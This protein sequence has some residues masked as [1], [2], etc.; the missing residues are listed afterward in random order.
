MLLY[1]LEIVEGGV[2]VVGTRQV[3]ELGHKVGGVHQAL[4]GC[5]DILGLFAAEVD[6]GVAAVFDDFNTF[7]DVAVVFLQLGELLQCGDEFVALGEGGVGG[8]GVEFVE[9]FFVGVPD[10]AVLLAAL[11]LYAVAV[12]C[13]FLAQVDDGEVALLHGDEV[14]ELTDIFVVFGNVFEGD[15]DL[16]PFEGLQVR[17]VD[18][19]MV[20]PGAQFEG[21]GEVFNALVVRVVAKHA[22]YESGL[23]G[24]EFFQLA[25]AVVVGVVA[26]KV[27][28]V[29][30][31]E[32][33][34]VEVFQLLDFCFV[35]YI[36][37]V[38]D[39]GDFRVF[40]LDGFFEFGKPLVF[41]A[42]YSLSFGA[43]TFLSGNAFGLQSF[44]LQVVVVVGIFVEH[45]GGL[46]HLSGVG[47]CVDDAMR[48]VDP[49]H[50]AIPFIVVLN[51]ADHRVDAYSLLAAPLAH[52][53]VGVGLHLLQAVHHHAE[54]VFAVDDA[55]VD[56]ECGAE[57]PHVVAIHRVV[58][59]CRQGVG[60]LCPCCDGQ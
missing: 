38:A 17:L 53:R 31:S 3:D 27:V 22:V 8:N 45:V 35:A 39:G 21:V 11:L 13:Y 16:H 9:H 54:V 55:G 44:L 57:L 26:G 29:V 52:Q 56:V 47:S 30:D 60:H 59:V 10:V 28:V 48:G 25:E 32:V 41:L 50:F 18:V 46:P 36:V 49:S 37:G 20:L 4:V 19:G 14:A 12:A 6:D 24:F 58:V 42:L 40:L 43:G 15:M 34:V 51:A 33:G 2:V 23:E 5:G 7:D 1:G